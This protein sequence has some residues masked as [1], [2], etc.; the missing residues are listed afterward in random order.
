MRNYKNIRYWL[1]F[2]GGLLAACETIVEL[3]LPTPEPRLVVNS[4]V[5]PD[6]VFMV[7]V[8]A[9]RGALVTQPYTLITEATVQVYQ[10]GQYWGDLTHTGKG[11]YRSA[12]FPQAL[13]QY[14]IKVTAPGFPSASAS[15]TL[16]ALP[17]ITDVKA[18]PIASTSNSVDPSV[19]ASFVLIDDAA[20]EDFYYVQAYTPDSSIFTD[21]KSYNRSVSVSFLSPSE[22]EFSMEDRYFFSDRLFNG[23]SLPLR[24]KLDVSHD[25]TAYVRVAHISKAYYEYVRN[26]RRQS[27]ADVDP[28][29]AGPVTVPNNIQDGF[30][31]FGSYAARVLTI[32][33]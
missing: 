15:T 7:E 18:I 19:E 17:G 4:V 28:T 29:L 30:G 9:N 33:P 32:R 26:L 1:P 12:K 27:Y 16:P 14:E 3:E 31:L 13:G 21:F 20:Q 5:N 24:L 11:R 10:D 6:S 23:Q 25:K 8:S 22:E 2:L